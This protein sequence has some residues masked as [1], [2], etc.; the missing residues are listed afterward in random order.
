[1]DD[2]KFRTVLTVGELTG[3]IAGLLEDAFP[4]VW[5]QGEISGLASPSS[6]HIYFTLKDDAAQI[7]VVLFKNQARSLGLSGASGGRSVIGD[8]GMAFSPESR[9]RSEQPPWRLADGQHV[10]VMG[11]IGIYPPRGEYQLIAD[12]IEPVG[13]GAMMLALEALK[14]RLSEKGYF[15]D[16]R[17]RRLPYLPKGIAVVTSGTGAALFDILKVIF[18]RMPKSRV[19]VVPVR[20]QGEGAEHEIARGVQLVNRV[21]LADVIIVGR[22]GGSLEDLWAF[23]TEVVADALFASEIPVISAVGHE[24]D[25]TVADLVADVRAP[26]PTAAAELVTPRL[27]DLLLTLDGFEQRL[28]AQTRYLISRYR[29]RLASLG[30]RIRTPRQDLDR[31]RLRFAMASSRVRAAMAGGV[32]GRMSFLTSLSHALARLSPEAVLARGYSITERAD[33]GAIIRSSSDIEVGR[34][35]RIRLHKGMLFADITRKEPDETS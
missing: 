14:K 16:E 34:T 4:F 13:I 21:G 28:T 25:F 26:T 20:V 11:R 18:G 32:S 23:N 15:A 5:V 29:E 27:D 6:G 35:A 33:D 31:L 3:L 22:G 10:L 1:M 17:K 12:H 30:S 19:L 9:P 24:I 8:A 2:I 7:R